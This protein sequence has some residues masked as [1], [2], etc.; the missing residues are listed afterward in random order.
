[1]LDCIARCLFEL[2]HALNEKLDIAIQFGPADEYEFRAVLTKKDGRTRVKEALEAIS[3]LHAHASVQ[4]DKE[5]IEAEIKAN[6]GID[7]F[8]SLVRAGVAKEYRRI[9][10]AAM[11]RLAMRGSA[12]MV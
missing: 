7:E 9:S 8:D 11:A 12:A 2:Y 10:A 1:M 6:V 4:T 5:M 3:V